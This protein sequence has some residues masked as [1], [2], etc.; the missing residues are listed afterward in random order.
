[1]IPVTV[2]IKANHL[3]YFIFEMCNLDVFGKESDECFQAVKLKLSNG[4]D[5][6]ELGKLTGDVNL[7]VKLPNDLKCEHCVFR[8]TWTTG[9]IET[10]NELTC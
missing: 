9:N 8:W 3:G 2:W 4:D 1:M 5:R 7:S 6:F 10:L